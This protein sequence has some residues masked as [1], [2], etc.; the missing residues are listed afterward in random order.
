MN[1]IYGPWCNSGD[2]A[3]ESA[4]NL[5]PPGEEPLSLLKY[6]AGATLVVRL[7]DGTERSRPVDVVYSE[8]RGQWLAVLYPAT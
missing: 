1:N 7:P 8:Q 4:R 5:L 2:D 3:L 6:S